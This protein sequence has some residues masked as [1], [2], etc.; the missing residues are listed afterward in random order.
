MCL[1]EDQRGLFNPK[2]TRTTLEEKFILESLIKLVKSLIID[3]MRSIWSC[4]LVCQLCILR[5]PL[6][7]LMRKST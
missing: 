7:L 3:L 1:M 5:T 2:Q 4:F 6:L